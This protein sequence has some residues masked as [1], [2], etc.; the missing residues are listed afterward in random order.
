M[1]IQARGCTPTS[2]IFAP[3]ESQSFSSSSSSMKMRE[4]YYLTELTKMKTIWFRPGFEPF[5][6]S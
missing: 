1:F 5:Q 6:Q 2:A 3:A 4:K